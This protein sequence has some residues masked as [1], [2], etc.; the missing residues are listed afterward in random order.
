MAQKVI[1]AVK[2]DG[3]LNVEYEGFVGN[4]CFDEADKLK[5]AL[6]AYGLDMEVTKVI[7]SKQEVEVR[8]LEQSAGT[9]R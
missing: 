9:G 2:G 8:R 7:D 4:S 5:A 1:V 3:R 6:K